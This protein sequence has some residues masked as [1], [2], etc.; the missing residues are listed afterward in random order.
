MMQDIIF[1]V[2]TYT[3]FHTL[4]PFL[5][6]LEG[7]LASLKSQPLDPILSQ[8][9][10]VHPIDSP[11]LKVH[12]NVIIPITPGLSSGPFPLDLANQNPAN[13][14]TLPMRVIYPAHLIILD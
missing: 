13:N 14:S 10:P 1:K 8:P 2:V 7:P 6:E 11:I 12:L 9:D 4:S 5:M 3:A